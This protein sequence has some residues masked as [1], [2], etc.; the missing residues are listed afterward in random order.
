MGQVS[1]R[2]PR[3]VVKPPTQHGGPPPGPSSFLR[4]LPVHKLETSSNLPVEGPI[5]DSVADEVDVTLQ[6]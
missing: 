2:R 4:F 6:K 1:S 5:S 3:D